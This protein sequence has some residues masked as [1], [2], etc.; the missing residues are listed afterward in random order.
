LI[1]P[2][3]DKPDSSVDGESR[4]DRR[5]RRKEACDAAWQAFPELH[6][7]HWA[8]RLAEDRW[9]VLTSEGATLA[10]INEGMKS[11]RMVAFRS[12][13]EVRV[14]GGPVY[15]RRR[16]GVLLRSKRHFIEADSGI[17]VLRTLGQHWDR[18]AFGKIELLTD[19][20]QAAVGTQLLRFPVEATKPQNALMR[21]VDNSDRTIL[22]FRR[23]VALKQLVKV[24]EDAGI[25]IAV[26]PSVQPTSELLLIAAVA[27]PWIVTFFMSGGGG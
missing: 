16:S 7:R 22:T 20:S 23:P 2:E 26:S 25:D 21:A 1:V 24:P 9:A 6:G 4:K 11:T 3:S 13:R 15:H 19:E 10:T 5:D 18:R 17:P 8:I 12:I 14:S 27:S